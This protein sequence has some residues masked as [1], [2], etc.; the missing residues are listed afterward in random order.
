[1]PSRGENQCLKSSC[2]DKQTPFAKD[3]IKTGNLSNEFFFAMKALFSQAN[4]CFC[5][6]DVILILIILMLVQEGKCHEVF[7]IK[8]V[9]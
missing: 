2:K 7:D 5:T 9:K 3:A 1:M 4:V 6:N 8:K